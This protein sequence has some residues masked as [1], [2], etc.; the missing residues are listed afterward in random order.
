[1]ASSA[2]LTRLSSGGRPFMAGRIGSR[3]V[4]PRQNQRRAMSDSAWIVDVTEENFASTVVEAC[5]ERPVILDFWAPTCPPGRVLGPILEKLT[6][7]KKG[8]V[9][10]AKVNTEE[11]PHLAGEFD[12]DRIPT[13]KVLFRKKLLTEFVGLVPEESLRDL[14]DKLG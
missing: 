13:V 3:R 9:I 11:A 10:L 8:R 5:E 4:G 2:G 6:R 1:V 12:V 7:E 14:F